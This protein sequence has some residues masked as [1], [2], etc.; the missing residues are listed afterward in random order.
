MEEL[1]I[2][3]LLQGSDRRERGHA[4][5]A[6]L[7]LLHWLSLLQEVLVKLSLQRCQPETE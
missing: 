2:A 4:D 7:Q 3:E 6:L 5:L 1:T